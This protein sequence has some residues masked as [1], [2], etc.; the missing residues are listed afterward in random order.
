MWS[1]E[2]VAE[3]PLSPVAIWRV[4][5]DLDHWVDWDTSMERGEILGLFRVGT[6]VSMTP[7]C[8]GPIVS[9]IAEAVENE[10]YA[11]ECQMDGLTPRFRHTLPPLPGGGTRIAHR[12]EIRG[13][14]ADRV[15]PE[16]G[17]AITGDFPAA[18]AALMGV[19]DR[20]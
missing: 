3:T 10:R 16:L 8:Q 20:G 17:P 14:A 15:G 5:R 13:P 18:M 9:T 11:D 6:K 12:L 1:H 19:A 2:Y 7:K 4:L